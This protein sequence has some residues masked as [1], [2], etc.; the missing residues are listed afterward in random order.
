MTS[1]IIENM[2]P[3]M[4]AA[5]VLF[6]LLGYP[7]AFSLGAVGLIFGLIGIELGLFAPD[8]L[9]A[10]PERIYGVMSNDTLLAIPFFTFMGLV[11]ERSGMAEDLLD[12]IG[13]LF[14]TVRGG[15]A[16]AV[17]FVG[18]LLAAT[19]G[20]VAASVISMGLISLPIMLRYGYDRRVA[21]GV[22]AASGTLAQII[23]PSLVLIVMADQLG[24]SVGDMYEGAFLP[25]IFLAGLYAFY[26]FI[27]T[28]LYPAAVPGLPADA[29]GFKETEVGLRNALARVNGV[30]LLVSALAALAFL[31]YQLYAAAK[32]GTLLPDA[33]K[34]DAAVVFA[35][36]VGILLQVAAIAALLWSLTRLARRVQLGG[37][38]RGLL[39]LLVLAIASAFFG[40]FMMRDST[41]HGADFVVLS[42]FN[43][44]IFAFAVAVVNWLSARFL[45]F[46]FLS[47]MA[48][49]TTFVMVPP[50]FLIFLVLGTIFIG[51]ATPTEGGAM[52]A[53]GALILGAMKRR[54]TWDLVRQAVESTAKLSAFVVFILVGARVFS[55]TFY[56]VS[57]HIW[58]EN[59]LTSL[60]GGQIGFLIFVNSF[61]FV[62]A[63]FLDFFELAFIVIPLLGPAAEHLGIDLIWFGVILGV[64]MQTSFM[65]PPFGFALF[66]L[67]SVAPRES[68]IDR[69][70][71]KRTDGVTT[72]QIYWGAVPFVV[73]QVIMVLLVILFPAMVMH[74]KGAASTVDPNKVKIEIPQIDLPPLDFGPSK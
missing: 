41:T 50:L 26:V 8:F 15:L 49:Q 30:L 6:L 20:V 11:L 40:V 71:G 25:G 47:K 46:H 2:A 59:L 28:L 10:L 4:F 17:V 69:V 73:I 18:A 70:T 54:L 64:N 68:F 33:S 5:L 43:G 13:Q 9:Q 36:Y 58:V 3:I 1:F 27:I 16:Y 37:D 7:A 48:Q 21:S 60:P 67:R 34:V 24:R 74:Y 51:V 35:N 63:F 31:S 52:G 62:L 14:G 57:G 38:E 29:V 53:S 72:G 19:T 66:Y 42:M 39:S 65:H 55:L 22:I 56:G 61:V 23:P 12:T 45:G 44:I 32:A